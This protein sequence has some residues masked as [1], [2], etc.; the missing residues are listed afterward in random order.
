MVIDYIFKITVLGDVYTGK[1]TLIDQLKYPSLKSN[2]EQYLTTVGVEY[3]TV[4][5]EH[6][7]NDEQKNIKLGIWDTS[8]DEIFASILKSYYNVSAIVAVFS[9]DNI[10]SFENVVKKIKY[11]RGKY[12]N[13]PQVLL[14]R[15]KSDLKNDISQ[16]EINEVIDKYNCLYFSCNS[17][18]GD[19]VFNAFEYLKGSIYKSF[20]SSGLNEKF[21]GIMTTTKIN[22]ED[23]QN[24]CWDFFW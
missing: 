14:I 4:V 17:L 5:M 1:T 16:E 12:G 11:F 13:L 18:T 19:N 9:G 20:L 6:M 23:Q 10:D 8:G 22:Y 7:E 2:T 21:P 15:N 3:Q 24:S